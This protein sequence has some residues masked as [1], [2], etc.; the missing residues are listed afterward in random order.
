MLLYTNIMQAWEPLELPRKLFVGFL[1]KTSSIIASFP[2]LNA[3]SSNKCQSSFFLS[4]SLWLHREV[5]QQHNEN[6]L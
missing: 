6:M 4:S 3:A 2:L 5:I 1:Q